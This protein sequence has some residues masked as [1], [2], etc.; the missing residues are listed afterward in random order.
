MSNLVTL[1]TDYGTKDYFVGSLKGAILTSCPGSTL[2]D[3]SHNIKSY[4]IVQGAFVVK[5][6]YINFPPGTIHVINIHSQRGGVTNL[7]GLTYNQHHFI[8]PDNGI[9]TL[10]FNE[11]DI[12]Y[13]HLPSDEGTPGAFKRSIAQA[14]KGMV[15]HGGF[16]QFSRQT[17]QVIRRILLK[18]V[19]SSSHIRA[20]VIH[21]DHYG[22]AIINID[23]DLFE[24]TCA[25]RDFALHYKRLDP[26]TRILNHYYE[27]PIGEVLALFNDAGYLEIAVNMGRADTLLGLKIDDTVQIDFS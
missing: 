1:T 20:S 15:T 5:N 27:A 14:V 3:I 21:V 4:D 12:K 17:E 10:M 2:V 23:R 7:L 26:L 9:F 18:P 24:K 16:A 6:V 22:N 13:F 25:G 8:G 11:D 19:I